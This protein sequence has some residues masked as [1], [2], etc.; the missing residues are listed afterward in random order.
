MEHLESTAINTYKIHC[1]FVILGKYLP[2]F[3]LFQN[4]GLPLSVTPQPTIHPLGIF[5]EQLIHKAIAEDQGRGT[6]LWQD[7]VPA[8]RE[9]SKKACACDDGPSSQKVPTGDFP[10]PTGERHQCGTVVSGYLRTHCSVGP[11]KAGTES[12]SP[13]KS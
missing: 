8:S 3:G 6:E 11:L 1:S 12:Y 10:Q 2:L 13:A 4:L 9:R 7:I 5:T